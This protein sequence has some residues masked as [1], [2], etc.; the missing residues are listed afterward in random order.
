MHAQK[1][2]LD[3]AGY[4]PVPRF[5]QLPEQSGIYCVYAHRSRVIIPHRL[6]YIGES[7]N[8]QVRVSK[9]ELW[10]TWFQAL[11]GNERQL[12]FSAALISPDGARER[13][14]AAMIHHHQPPCNVE[15]KDNFPFDRTTV[16]IT[17][18]GARLSGYFTVN[19]T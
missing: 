18:R 5:D 19:C 2:A 17:G 10:Q 16:T 3:F 9:H 12:S 7:Q 13:A 14:E 8:V 4:Y 1:Y 6:L 11:T 15:Y